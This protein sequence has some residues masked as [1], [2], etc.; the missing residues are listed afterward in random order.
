MARMQGDEALG[1]VDR[2]VIGIT[3]ILRIGLH[4]LRLGGPGRIGMLAL[5][6]AESLGRGTVLAR[7]HLFEALVVER[8][9]R[10]GLVGSIEIG[11]NG[12]ARSGS[13]LRRC[14]R[15]AVEQ[16]GHARTGAKRQRDR[17]HGTKAQPCCKPDASQRNKGQSSNSRC[18]IGRLLPLHDPGFQQPQ[19]VRCRKPG[20]FAKCCSSLVWSAFCQ[21]LAPDPIRG[22]ST[23]ATALQCL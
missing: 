23:L 3:L 13:C 4:E 8:S 6:L 7:L 15:S 5:D 19:A 18:Q 22:C 2:L 16:I 9:Y 1:R 14:R 10:L 12:I 21:K 17:D 11:R 20:F